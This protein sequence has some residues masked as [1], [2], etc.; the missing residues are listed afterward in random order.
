MLFRSKMVLKLGNSENDGMADFA[1]RGEQYLFYRTVQTLQ[2]TDLIVSHN[3][4]IFGLFECDIL[5]SSL[6]VNSTGKTLKS[7]LNIEANGV[8]HKREKKRKFCKMR[9]DW[10]EARGVAIERINL[11]DLRSMTDSHVH[12]W[13]RRCVKRAFGAD[14]YKNEIKL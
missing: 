14:Y 9:D 7:V 10:L 5:V 1:S 12:N 8:H 4:H 3:Q 11:Q 2:D 6:V 13:L